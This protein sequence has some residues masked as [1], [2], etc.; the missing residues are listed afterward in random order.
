MSKSR[1]NSN[2]KTADV[3][4]E[5][6]QHNIRE[7]LENAREKVLEGYEKVSDKAH[8]V[9]DNAADV[10]LNDVVK[11]ARKYYKRNPGKC[12]LIAAGSGL[13]AGLMLS[14]RRR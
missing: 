13:F 12:L 6:V 7:G 9:W 11:S 4:D 2:D 1:E 10:T 5:E 8:E 14:G 3:I